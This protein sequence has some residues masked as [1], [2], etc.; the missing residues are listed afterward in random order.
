MLSKGIVSTDNYLQE[1]NLSE[2]FIRIEKTI[3]CFN[4]FFLFKK[5]EHSF[6]I[7]ERY[8]NEKKP[9]YIIKKEVWTDCA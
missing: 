1:K 4:F 6:T 2:K 3:Y 9:E 5:M 8:I 7:L